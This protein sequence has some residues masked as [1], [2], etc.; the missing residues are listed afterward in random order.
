MDK[1]LEHYFFHKRNFLDEGYCNNC[2]DELI[3]LNWKKHTWYSPR[4]DELVSRSGDNE[5]ELLD[6][7][8][9]SSAAKIND[10][11]IQG[12]RAAILEY[13]EEFKF[14]WFV[15]WD[16]YCAIKFMRYLPG[17]TMKNHCDHI[18]HMFDGDRKGIPIL[19]IIGILNDDYEG[20]N[21]I[22]FGDKKIDTKKGDLIIFPSNFLY[23]H[24]ITPVTKGVRYSY[25][26]W[27]W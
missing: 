21:L 18:R 25:T 24:E 13:I 9:L 10:S 11:I 5:P 23:P 7:D 26:S 1:N 20:G 27:V 22:M 12:L 4:T 6:Y 3:D 2:I 17:Q 14:D 15:G 19:S 8:R 16:G